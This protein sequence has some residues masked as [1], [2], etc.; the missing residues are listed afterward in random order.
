V[1]ND[2]RIVQGCARNEKT[3]GTEATA[4]FGDEVV[5]VEDTVKRQ[6]PSSSL[7][8]RKIW[9]AVLVANVP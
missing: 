4:P 9:D 8:W 6:L 2:S 3:H 5:A 7:I 1:K